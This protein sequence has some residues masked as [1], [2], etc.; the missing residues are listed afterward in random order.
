MSVNEVSATSTRVESGPPNRAQKAKEP[1]PK[2]ETAA[3]KDPED[4]ISISGNQQMESAEKSEESGMSKKAQEI[5]ALIDSDQYKQPDGV[6]L[7]RSF[8]MG[9]VAGF[10]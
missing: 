3:A 9:A 10:A 2:K 8:L 6:E 4:K 1:E 7:A 5:K